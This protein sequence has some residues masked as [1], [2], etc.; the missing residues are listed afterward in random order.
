[1]LKENI[2]PQQHEPPR[3]IE[4]FIAERP[5]T[6]RKLSAEEI[7]TPL[8]ILYGSSSTPHDFYKTL[9]FLKEVDHTARTITLQNG[10]NAEPHRCYHESHN[11]P[12]IIRMDDILEYHIIHTNKSSK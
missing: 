5:E 9:G 8:G 6:L 3:G 12:T 4:K 11:I 2:P 10:I 1:M 7:G